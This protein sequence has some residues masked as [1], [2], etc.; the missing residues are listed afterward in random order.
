MESSNYF[1]NNYLRSIV[2]KQDKTRPLMIPE[3]DTPYHFR[4]KEMTPF[5]KN[6]VIQL[7]ILENPD[8]YTNTHVS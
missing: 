8:L 5:E 3:L 6:Q 7:K 2:Q 4:Q 1:Q